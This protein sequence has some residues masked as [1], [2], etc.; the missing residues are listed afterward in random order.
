M[1]DEVR[2]LIEYRMK[3][4]YDAL[5]EATILLERKKARGARNG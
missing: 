1:N 2:A 5:E 4:A 3:E